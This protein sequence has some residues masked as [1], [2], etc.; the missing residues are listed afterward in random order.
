ML[1][2]T[3]T[4][5]KEAGIGVVHVHTE[6]LGGSILGRIEACSMMSLILE[7]LVWRHLK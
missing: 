2:D 3:S 1:R 6:W 5:A 7:V 4:V